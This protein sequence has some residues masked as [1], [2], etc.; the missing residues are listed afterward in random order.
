MNPQE[1]LV[2]AQQAMS[3][4]RVFGDPIQVGDTTV[5]PA[6]VVGGGGGGGARGT[7]ESGV[8]FGLKAKPAGAYILKN[9]R[10]CWR[11]AVD[12]NKIV[13]G[14]QLVAIAAILVIGPGLRAWCGRQK[15]TSV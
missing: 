6:A 10:V 4:R 7:E 2:N 14:G 12:V 11:P 13:L 5:I 8:G 15:T 1:V 9:N 3:V